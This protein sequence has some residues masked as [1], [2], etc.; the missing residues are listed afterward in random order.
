MTH[1]YDGDTFT[2]T[3]P[4]G[5]ERTF[6]VNFE[7]DTDAD[8]P[9]ERNDGHGVVSDWTTRDKRPGERV[10]TSDRGSYR[11]YDV[12]ES[13]RIAKRDL[14]DAPPFGQGTRAQHAARAVNADFEYLRRWCADLWSY[15]GVVVTSIPEGADPDEVDTDYSHALWRIESDAEDY[16]QEV[17]AELAEEIER[18]QVKEGAERQHWDARDVITR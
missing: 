18:E 4:D 7:H 6:R 14:W 16:L 3:G 12:Q 17:A 1:L 11:Y 8:A 13:T 2:R 9:W 15:V 10:L 5:V